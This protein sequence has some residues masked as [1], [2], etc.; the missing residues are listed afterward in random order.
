LRAR[1]LCDSATVPLTQELL[2]QMT[3][4]RRNAI[5][6]VAHSLQPA[7]IIRY[8]RGQM[9][10]SDI[11]ALEAMS[12]ACYAAVKKF[13]AWRWNPAREAVSRAGVAQPVCM[14]TCTQAEIGIAICSIANLSPE[15]HDGSVTRARNGEFAT[16][17]HQLGKTGGG[18]GNDGASIQRFPFCTIGG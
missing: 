4:V 17:I 5:S 2:A 15:S 7:G 9:E 6:L 13:H 3:G 16:A 12:C 14:P 1:D 18:F 11:R 8:S 10:I